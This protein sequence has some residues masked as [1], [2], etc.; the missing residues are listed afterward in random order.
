MKMRSC[1]EII[2]IVDHQEDLSFFQR[3]E[4]M[5]HLMMCRHCY[6]FAKH[7]KIIKRGYG[8][9]IKKKLDNEKNN[10]SQIEKKIISKFKNNK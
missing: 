10:I 5:L 7:L 1:R 6:R 3:L 2:K 4:V 8:A 9:F